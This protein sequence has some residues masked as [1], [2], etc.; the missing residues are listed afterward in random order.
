M[1]AKGIFEN[2][3][4]KMKELYPSILIGLEK[5]EEYYRIYFYLEDFDINDM[6]FN[7][8]I[9]GVI[10]ETFYKNGIFNLGQT[11]FNLERAKKVFPELQNEKPIELKLNFRSEFFDVIDEFE[12]INR[13]EYTLEL[14]R[15]FKKMIE[16]TTRKRINA[17]KTDFEN[18]VKLENF[19][20][21]TENFGKRNIELALAS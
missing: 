13:V 6:D 9:G 4:K 5:I 8:K 17:K 20:N 15:V 19:E 1:D 10:K 16:N 7:E 18:I 21:S 2:F 3:K 12:K 14:K 11:H